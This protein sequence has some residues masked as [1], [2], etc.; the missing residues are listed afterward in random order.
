MTCFPSSSAA[1]GKETHFAAILRCELF[2]KV[3]C[4]SKILNFPKRSTVRRKEASIGLVRQS[5]SMI[6]VDIQRHSEF[7]SACCL[8][9]ITSTVVLHSSQFGTASLV[10]RSYRLLQSVIKR[11]F[12]E[13]RNE[14]S[15]YCGRAHSMSLCTWSRSYHST[16]LF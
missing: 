4:S 16:N 10:T 8:I 15:G 5:A 11:A 9:S 14:C 2:C 12:W 3:C 1:S 6:A 13:V 7:P